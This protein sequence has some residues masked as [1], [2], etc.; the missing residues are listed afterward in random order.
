MR[1]V[2]SFDFTLQLSDSG[3]THF[4]HIQTAGCVTE[5]CC[6]FHACCS[7]E[8]FLLFLCDFLWRL[9]WDSSPCLW[10][11][12]WC[13]FDLLSFTALSDN[14]LLSPEASDSELL[15]S[16]SSSSLLVFFSRCRR[17][18]LLCLCDDFFL[19]LELWCFL[20]KKQITTCTVKQ[21]KVKAFKWTTCMKLTVCFC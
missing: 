4:M 20:C 21:E 10:R 17:L 9:L 2:R 12:L 5:A 13:C 7:L 8:C 6:Q 19:L 1:S 11:C 14:C 18:D 15:S 16:D 3:H